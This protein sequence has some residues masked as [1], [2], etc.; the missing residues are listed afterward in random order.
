MAQER[1][2]ID[3]DIRAIRE[4]F[5]KFEK[6]NKEVHNKLL[7][8]LQGNSEPEKG[9]VTKVALTQASIGRLMVW[10]LIIS[11]AILGIAFK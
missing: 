5:E 6:E 4:A 10:M 11:V 1:R 3:T 8:I 9:L 2:M 7:K